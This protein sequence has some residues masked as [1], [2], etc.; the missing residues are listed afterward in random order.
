MIKLVI[1]LS[2]CTEDSD[3]DTENCFYCLSSGI[4][5]Q[6]GFGY[7]DSNICGIG[8]GDCDEGT[9]PAGLSCG[10]RNNFLDYHPNLGHCSGTSSAEACTGKK[11]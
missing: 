6:Y 9:C 8:D 11:I 10:I 7:C 5:S 3:C 4:C 2:F 1:E